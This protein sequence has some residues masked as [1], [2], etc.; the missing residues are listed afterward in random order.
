MTPAAA[1]VI[2]EN[3]FV[4]D[5]ETAPWPA[6]IC[7]AEYV[8]LPPA[9]VLVLALA[10]LPV[11]EITDEFALNVRFVVVPI[12]QMVAL[13]VADSVHVPLPRFIVLVPLPD[14]LNAAEAVSVM[15]GLF[16]LKSKVPVNAPHVSDV[17]VLLA[18][19][20]AA[21]VTVPP[22]D[23]PSNVTVSADVGA[24]WFPVPLLVADQW[25]L[26]VLSHVPVPL[27][28]NRLAVA[29]LPRLLPTPSRGQPVAAHTQCPAIP[30]VVPEV[31]KLCPR[32]YMV[33]MEFTTSHM[34]RNAC[35][36][37]ALK[38][39]PTPFLVFPTRHSC[40]TLF[41]FPAAP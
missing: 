3:V 40:L 26:L 39:S 4:P 33:C 25:P 27:T 17:M 41:A 6:L 8:R 29:H 12:S 11:R 32:I 9:N 10:A 16:A 7:R 14:P 31:R 36:V 21:T 2:V 38:N 5:T 23:E 22:P 34:T 24:A 1:T 20:V 13:P 19:I 35:V 15:L 30:Y 37:V 18:L 28:Q